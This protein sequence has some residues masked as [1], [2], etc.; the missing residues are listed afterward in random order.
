MQ[1][2]IVSNGL[3][4]K[5]FNFTWK[6]SSCWIKFTTCF[7]SNEKCGMEDKIPVSNLDLQIDSSLLAD[8]DDE[9]ESLDMD[10]AEE[11]ADE[12]KIKDSIAGM[13]N[14]N[15]LFMYWTEENW[16]VDCGSSLQN[17]NLPFEDEANAQE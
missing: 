13:Q 12:E 11:T 9:D 6:I 2:I 15:L 7:L 8:T 5:W 14:D 4:G 3:F 16:L 1:D 17:N 10:I